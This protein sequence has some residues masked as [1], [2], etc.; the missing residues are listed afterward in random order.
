MRCKLFPSKGLGCQQ[1]RGWLQTAAHAG[2]R[3]ST[4]TLLFLHSTSELAEVISL[5]ATCL[6]QTLG[7]CPSSPQNCTISVC[8]RLGQLLTAWYHTSKGRR[9]STSKSRQFHP[10]LWPQISLPNLDQ[11]QA[12]FFRHET[13]DE[14]KP[15]LDTI[16]RRTKKEV[17]GYGHTPWELHETHNP[18]AKTCGQVVPLNRKFSVTWNLVEPGILFKKLFHFPELFIL[19]G[20]AIVYTSTGTSSVFIHWQQIYPTGNIQS[21][22]LSQKLSI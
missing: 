22:K 5:V 9:L 15:S 1:D 6:P 17:I 4:W 14:L 7:F 18:Q 8:S 3:L 12:S 16:E 11:M 21:F 13:K 20:D 19:Q 10:A 2:G